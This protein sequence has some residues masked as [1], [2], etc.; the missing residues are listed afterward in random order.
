L[1]FGVLCKRVSTILSA[2]HA[3][4]K[5]FLQ[6]YNFIFASFAVQ[7]VLTYTLKMASKIL[8]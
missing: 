2:L 1:R 7:A 5:W 6:F 3:M 8:M 4:A